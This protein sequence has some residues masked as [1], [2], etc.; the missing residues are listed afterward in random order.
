MSK[1]RKKGFRLALRETGN[2]ES[3]DTHTLHG[4][5]LSRKKTIRKGF[6]HNA[7]PTEGQEIPKKTR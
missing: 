3:A 4:V 7:V 2:K 5:N 6:P 1:N